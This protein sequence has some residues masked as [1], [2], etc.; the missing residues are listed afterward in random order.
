LGRLLREAEKEMVRRQRQRDRVTEALTAT[1][2]HKELIRLG[3]ELDE[4]QSALDE[5]EERWLSLAEE[6]E[7]GG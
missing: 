5:V 7:S 2:D 4:A 6:A 3:A 1:A